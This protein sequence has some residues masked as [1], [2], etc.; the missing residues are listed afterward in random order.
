MLGAVDDSTGESGAVERR[1]GEGRVWVN[2]SG[3]A[4]LGWPPLK[5]SGEGG[6]MGDGTMGVGASEMR[7]TMAVRLMFLHC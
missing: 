3:T 4:F 7:G 6:T 1:W 5:A 2:T